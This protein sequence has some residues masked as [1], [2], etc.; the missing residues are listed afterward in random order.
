M[1]IAHLSSPRAAHLP[2][3]DPPVPADVEIVVPVYNEAEQL[4]ASITALRSYLDSSFP[5]AT[6]VT[7][8]DNASTDDTWRIAT[9][10]PTSSPA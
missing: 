1:S 8:A 5:L 7:I 10:W 2:I 9:D 4:G 6:T 3:D